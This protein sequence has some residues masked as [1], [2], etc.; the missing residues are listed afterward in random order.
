MKKEEEKR[1]I[2]LSSVKVQNIDGSEVTMDFSKDIASITYNSTQDL[3]VVSACM[4]L[5]KTGKCEWSEKIKEDLSKTVTNLVR[6]VDG[7]QIPLGIVLKKAILDA[8]G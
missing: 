1:M 4:D 8:I 3:E 7:E 6:V 2:D 5:F